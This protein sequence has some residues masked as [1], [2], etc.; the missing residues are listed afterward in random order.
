MLAARV[1]PEKLTEDDAGFAIRVPE[2]HDCVAPLGV[3]TSRPAGRISLKAMP[4]RGEA[5]APGFVRVKVR[6]VDP[7]KGTVGA[8][9]EAPSVGAAA[10]FRLADAVLP[11]PPFVEV[12]A[13]VVLRKDPATVAVT[14]T[15][16]VQ[17]LP[18][19]IVAPAS[20][21][22][23]LPDVAVIVPPPQEPDSPLGVATTNPVGNV[24]IKA[25]PF[26]GSELAAGFVT[27]KVSEVD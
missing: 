6:V 11:V 24:S 7:F 3:A 22:L 13:P 14:F 15:A 1:P 18:A 4:V 26:N 2:L 9:N 25:T 5:L 21:T 12:T 16:N 8:E 23:P 17:E 19:A 10:D 27:V 20:A